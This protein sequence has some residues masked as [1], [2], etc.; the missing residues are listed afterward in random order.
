MIDDVSNQ[1]GS[2]LVVDRQEVVL[3]TESVGMHDQ[4]SRCVSDT[5]AGV[6]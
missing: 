2:R 5:S 4:A 6:S 1:H 3:G